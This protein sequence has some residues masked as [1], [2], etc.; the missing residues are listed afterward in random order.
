M[1]GDA[2]TSTMPKNE[3]SVFSTSKMQ[4]I[5]DFTGI[6]GIA[7]VA[8]SFAQAEAAGVGTLFDT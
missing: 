1:G 3:V 4:N 2:F 6:Q 5:A 7:I 8:L